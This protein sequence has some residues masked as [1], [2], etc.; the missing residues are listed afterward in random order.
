MNS[1][2]N[3][4]FSCSFGKYSYTSKRYF[5][6]IHRLEFWKRPNATTTKMHGTFPFKNIITKKIITKV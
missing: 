3:L 5:E 2:F 6:E 1:F 4:F